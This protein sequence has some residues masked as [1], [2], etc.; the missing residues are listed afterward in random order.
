MSITLTKK[1][2]YS[3]LQFLWKNIDPIQEI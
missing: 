2:H 3:Q 1:N